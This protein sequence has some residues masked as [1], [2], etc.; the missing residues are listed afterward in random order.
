M[1]NT[2]KITLIRECLVDIDS[3]EMSAVL[4][5]CLVTFLLEYKKILVDEYDR[6]EEK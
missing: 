1:S 4:K 5:I 2:E 6:G 3:I